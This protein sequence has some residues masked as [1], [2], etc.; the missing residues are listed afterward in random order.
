MLPVSAVAE[1]FTWTI[2]ALGADWFTPGICWLVRYAVITG[3]N[4]H[5]LICPLL[6]VK[7]T[8]N[9][10]LFA[11][12]VVPVVILTMKL[13][14]YPFTDVQVG[15]VPAPVPKFRLLQLSAP[16][17]MTQPPVPSARQIFVE[18][19][20]LPAAMLATPVLLT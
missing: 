12:G 10:G 17:S 5:A 4:E 1:L 19:T 11:A 7:V 6:A 20:V 9:S 3:E 18:F 15:L 8:V 13:E 2:V 16:P 14:S